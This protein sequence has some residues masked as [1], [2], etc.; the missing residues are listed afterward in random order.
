MK[1]NALKII[2]VLG[3]LFILT[4]YIYLI[5]S[6]SLA[7]NELNQLQTRKDSLTHEIANMELK[8][9]SLKNIISQSEDAKAQEKAKEV[10]LIIRRKYEDSTILAKQKRPNNYQEALKWEQLGFEF[11]LKKDIN[12]SIRA[13]EQA[14]R[15]YSSF[16]Q[17]YEIATYL[18]KNIKPL[19]DTT[20]IYW[21][22]V[23]KTIATDYS[24]KMNDKVK[25]ALQKKAQ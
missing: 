4:G 10:D 19:T 21:A 5:F 16:H 2:P 7:K 22:K 8:V 12:N 3:I 18:R 17:V 6:I 15:S 9:E 14:E 23:Y 13:F 20:S 24:W 25:D 11:L 1:T